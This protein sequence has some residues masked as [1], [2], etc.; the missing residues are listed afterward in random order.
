[1]VWGA[2]RRPPNAKL[3]GVSVQIRGKKK[4]A[5][6]PPPLIQHGEFKPRV[7]REQLRHFP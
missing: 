4:L 5:A 6:T 3:I 2:R 7:R 1:M